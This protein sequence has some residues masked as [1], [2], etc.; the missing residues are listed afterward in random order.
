MAGTRTR[1][2]DDRTHDELEQAFDELVRAVPD[3]VGRAIGWMRKPQARLVRLPLGILCIIGSFLWFLPVGLM[4]PSARPPADR[5]GRAVLAPPYRAHDALSARA[6]EAV[7]G[8]VGAAET[9]AR[10]TAA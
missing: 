5:A 6:L 4:V 10:G 1:T 7:A 2:T 8:M 3:S 9:S